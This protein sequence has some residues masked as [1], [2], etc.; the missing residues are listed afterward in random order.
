MEFEQSI[1]KLRVQVSFEMWS[2]LVLDEHTSH[3]AYLYSSFHLGDAMLLCHSPIDL[4]VGRDSM[5]MMWE[6]LR[7]P[8]QAEVLEAISTGSAMYAQ[9]R[10]SSSNGAAEQSILPV[11]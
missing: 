5:F 4:V 9:C 7:I 8:R 2:R 10:N 3:A 1:S 11:R 6:H